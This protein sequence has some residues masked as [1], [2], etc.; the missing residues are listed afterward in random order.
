MEQGLLAFILALVIGSVMGL[1]GAGGA[2]IAIPLFMQFLEMELREA[3]LYSLVVVVF[4][5]LFNLMSGGRKAMHTKLA[6]FITFFSLA[7]SSLG[8]PLKRVTPEWASIV[9]LSLIA[10]YALV[11]L[12]RPQKRINDRQEKKNISWP[13]SALV[14]IGLG[15]L[16]T[17]TGLG[18]GV[19]MLPLFLGF[20]ALPED[21]AVATSLLAVGL[22]SFGSLIVQMMKGSSEGIR[23]EFFPLVLGIFVS[24]LAIKW[25]MKKISPAGLNRLRK[26]IF[27]AVVAFALGKLWWSLLVVN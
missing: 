23:S 6:L 13:L 21:A 22:S 3:S 8:V 26:L 27:S 7:G 5:C 12:W 24:A 11:S 9:L 19:L 16:T 4:A 14:G 17:L 2:L 15:L 18:G 10:L 20:Y 25:G 1:T